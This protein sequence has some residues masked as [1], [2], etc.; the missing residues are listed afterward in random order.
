MFT[1]W[2]DFP[3]TW[4]WGPSARSGAILFRWVREG[5]RRP[6][7]GSAAR[8]LVAPGRRYPAQPINLSR[9]FDLTIP[10]QYEA[11]LAGMGMISNVIRFRVLPPNNKPTGP[12]IAWYDGKV[13]RFTMVWGA[14][15]HGLQMGT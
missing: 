9:I 3:G 6:Q 12:A 4:C 2:I 15:R 7:P 13:P 14:I 1:S 11:Q 10:G 5:Y 8:I